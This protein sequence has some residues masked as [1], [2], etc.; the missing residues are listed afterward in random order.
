LNNNIHIYHYTYLSLYI[1]ITIHIFRMNSN[2]NLEYKSHDPPRQLT[3]HGKIAMKKLKKM[4]ASDIYDIAP[5]DN[6]YHTLIAQLKP[7]QGLHAGKKY[8]LKIEINNKYPHNPPKCKFIVPIFHSNIYQDGSI[9]LD[10]LEDKWSPGYTFDAILNSILLLLE[11]PNPNSAA[12]DIA[13]QMEKKANSVLNSSTYK[14]MSVEDQNKMKLKIF[15]DYINKINEN[16][17]KHEE[18]YEKY[19]YLFK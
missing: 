13:G 7:K 15:A 11:T 17:Y 14:N 4:K 18:V 16:Y 2:S 12:N 6:T 19:E 5:I 10:I 1:F 3:R 8:I 9:C